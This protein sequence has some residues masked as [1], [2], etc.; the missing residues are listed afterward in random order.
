LTDKQLPVLKA[1]LEFL[2][3]NLGFD[4]Y[5]LYKLKVSSAIT[6]NHQKAR[7]NSKPSVLLLIKNIHVLHNYF[8]PFLD[9]M[10]F[11]TKKYRDFLDFKLICK[12]VYSGAHRR[13][14]IE[15]LILKL[16]LTMNNYRLST[17]LGSV[18]LLNETEKNLLLHAK[19]CI[20]HLSDGRLRD[21]LTNKIIHQHTSCVYEIL[22]LSN[23]KEAILMDTLSDVAKLVGVNIKTLSKHLDNSTQNKNNMVEVKGYHI[24]RV[25]VFY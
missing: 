17:Y 19:P 9:D 16:S 4:T 3:N 14:E 10:E 18:D 20:E 22:N 23:G 25:P 15:S 12:A 13:P 24:K 21:I 5:S 2:V 7:N 11:S 8:I 6:I 1:I